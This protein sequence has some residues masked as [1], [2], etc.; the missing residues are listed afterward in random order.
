MIIAF[1][2]QKGGVGKSTISFHYAAWLK[3]QGGSVAFYDAD[4]QLSS[5]SWLR[6]SGLDIPFAAI[7]PTDTD[8]VPNQ[9]FEL[10]ETA[11]FVVCDGPGGLGEITRTLLILADV[12]LFPITPS[13]LDASSLQKA[14]AQLKYASSISP[15]NPPITRIILNRTKKRSKLAKDVREAEGELGIEVL[16]QSV[17]DLDAFRVAALERTAVWELGRTGANA[18]RDL[19]A[20]F[21]EIALLQSP[22]GRVANG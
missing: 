4:A 17:R 7:D 3:E 20:L 19:R 12:A 15:T 1:V 5:S 21:T 9:V 13:F 8:S 16:P 10:A 22:V 6:A 14:K 18:S 2:N 11:D